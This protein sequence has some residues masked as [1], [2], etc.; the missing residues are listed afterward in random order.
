M[1]GG[2]YEA[3]I[4]GAICIS[5]LSS[6]GIAFTTGG[7]NDQI[8]TTCHGKKRLDYGGLGVGGCIKQVETRAVQLS[9]LLVIVALDCLNHEN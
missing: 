2:I 9:S 8:S 5:I 4:L 3:D 6:P 7:W 1:V